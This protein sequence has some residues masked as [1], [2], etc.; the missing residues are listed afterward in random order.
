M[1]VGMGSVSPKKSR[2]CRVVAG[3][4][5]LSWLVELS[6]VSEFEKRGLSFKQPFGTD[7]L[8]QWQNLPK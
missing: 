8:N 6:K 1:G 2:F 7:Y 5:F 4:G 3:G